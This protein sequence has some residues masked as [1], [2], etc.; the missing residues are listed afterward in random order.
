MQ[1]HLKHKNVTQFYLIHF[2]PIFH[3]YIP[4]NIRKQEVLSD[5]LGAMKWNI[6]IKQMGQP[7]FHYPNFGSQFIQ[8]YSSE[9]CNQFTVQLKI[10]CNLKS[11]MFYKP[12]KIWNPKRY[13]ISTGLSIYDVH[14]KLTVFGPPPFPPPTYPYHPQNEQ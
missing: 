7:Y 3:F 5:F 14:K 8:I 11:A 10:W 13:L 4:E 9:F 6:G 12:F 2:S 1:M